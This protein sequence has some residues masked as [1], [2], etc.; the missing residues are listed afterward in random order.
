MHSEPPREPGN[1]ACVY[2]LMIHVKSLVVKCV[3]VKIRSPSCVGGELIL[4]LWLW[5]APVLDQ[6]VL[7]MGV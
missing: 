5:L 7:L 6:A 1:V 4:V 3:G 2:M